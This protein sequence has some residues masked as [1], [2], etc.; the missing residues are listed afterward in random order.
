MEAVW[1]GQFFQAGQPGQVGQLRP[2]D[3][4]EQEEEQ[5]CAICFEQRPFIT[6]PC[7]C[8]VN[9]CA[10][11]WDRALASSATVR[12]LPSCP[13][14]RQ[15]LKVDYNAAE[16]GMIVS[17]TLEST[18]RA[19]EW[20]RKLYSKVRPVQIQLLRDYGTSISAASGP[21]A[22]SSDLQ[23]R[24]V[25]GATLELSCRRGRILRML[26]DTDPGWR[27]RGGDAEGALRRLLANA[28]V[29]CDLCEGVAAQTLCGVWTCKN[30]PHT[31]L[32][33]EGND[34]CERCF[35]CYSG[36]S[37][38]TSAEKKP[39]CALGVC[40]PFG[41]ISLCTPRVMTASCHPGCYCQTCTTTS[42]PPGSDAGAGCTVHI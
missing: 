31:V 15:P 1:H 35:E 22:T 4:L 21:Q 7:A 28:V 11:C 38:H 36:V 18:A 32:H 5:T 16:G 33:P 34:V 17:T 40:P 27:A 20:R 25:C 42:S 2:V 29:T 37:G 24:C 23:P 13:S 26:D 8:K 39:G 3:P 9:Y 12:G 30:G 6:V 10:I 19:G 14:C 41:G